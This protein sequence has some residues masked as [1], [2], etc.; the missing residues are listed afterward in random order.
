MATATA[1]APRSPRRAALDLRRNF[2]CYSA[3]ELTIEHDRRGRVDAVIRVLGQYYL[4]VLTAGNG[5]GLNESGI[6][7]SRRRQSEKGPLAIGSPAGVTLSLP[8]T[9]VLVWR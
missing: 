1:A 5:D 4:E 8:V 3:D 9:S 6:D 2:G 7:L